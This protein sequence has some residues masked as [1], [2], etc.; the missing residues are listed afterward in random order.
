MDKFWLWHYSNGKLIRSVA[1]KRWH[2]VAHA[3]PAAWSYP[4]TILFSPDGQKLFSCGDDGVIRVW[5]ING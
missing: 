2:T 1:G 3:H 4:T 5:G